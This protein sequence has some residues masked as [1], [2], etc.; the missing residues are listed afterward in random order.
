MSLRLPNDFTPEERELFDYLS[1]GCSTVWNSG[2]NEQIYKLLDDN[3]DK[4]ITCYVF[5]A[6]NTRRSLEPIL[7]LS[8]MQIHTKIKKIK[9]I[10]HAHY[11]SIHLL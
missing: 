10:L 8:K 3:L 4:F 1:S 7:G 11:K 5:E 9:S 6:G 2:T